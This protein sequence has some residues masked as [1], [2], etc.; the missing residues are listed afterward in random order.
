MQK[1]KDVAHLYKAFDGQSNTYQELG[2]ARDTTQS[3]ER[4]P[5]I[6]AL[7]EWTHADEV[8]PVRAIRTVAVQSEPPSMKTLA[9]VRATD[10]AR[11]V[12]ATAP[13]AA[14]SPLVTESQ[15]PQEAS[16]LAFFA[17]PEHGE[18]AAP[19]SA[20]DL[21]LVFDRITGRRTG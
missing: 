13:A 6:S 12:A 1:F 14:R 11:A 18:A 10:M 16:P 2:R 9:E 19:S 4:W 7:G 21:K 5:L 15:Q 20:F 8:K 17:K 3:R